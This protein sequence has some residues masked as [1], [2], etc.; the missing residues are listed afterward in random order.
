MFR[1]ITSYSWAFIWSII[2]LILLVAPSSAAPSVALFPGFDKLVHC[3]IFFVFT[4]FLLK[5]SI[6]HAKPR[7]SK[8]KTIIISLIISVVFAFGTEALQ[9]YLT[10]S[11]NGDWW[12]VF[13]DLVGSGMA[14]FSYMLLYRKR[15]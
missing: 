2:M 15:N 11:R 8:W 3:G 9:L 12:D 4:T 5:G 10:S 14:L 1:Y 7:E 6:V 13:A